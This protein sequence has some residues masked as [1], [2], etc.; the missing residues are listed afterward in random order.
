[1]VLAASGSG[2]SPQIMFIK[3]LMAIGL[4]QSR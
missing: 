1:M 2:S 3:E 4:T